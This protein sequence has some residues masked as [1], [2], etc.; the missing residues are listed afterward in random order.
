MKKFIYFFIICTVPFFSYGQ[1]TQNKNHVYSVSYKVAVTDGNQAAV[2]E[3]DKNQQVTYFD[4]LGRPT[5]SIIPNI[6]GNQEDVIS[7]FEYDD[8]GKQTKSYLPYT[9][10]LTNNLGFVSNPNVGLSSYYQTKYP[11]DFQNGINPYSETKLENSPAP[12]VLK[13]SAPGSDWKIQSTNDDHTVK[14]E[15]LFNGTNEIL[16]FEVEYTND[17]FM[18]PNIVFKGFYNQNELFITRVKNENWVTSD[19][20]LNTTETISDKNGRTILYRSFD[21]INNVVTSLD[22]YSTYDYFGNLIYTISPKASE[23]FVVTQIGVQ[24]NYNQTITYGEL[25]NYTPAFQLNATAASLSQQGTDILSLNISFSLTKGK[26]LKTGKIATL[27]ATYPDIILGNITN[28][29]YNFQ[30]SIFDNKLVI[31]DIAGIPLPT[32]NSYSYTFNTSIP[33]GAYMPPIGPE[34]LDE[35]CYQYKYDTKNRLI[36]KKLPGK[37]WQYIVYDKLNRPILTQDAIQRPQTLW[38]FVKYD[39]YSRVVYSGETLLSDTRASLQSQ[40][41][42]TTNPVLFESKTTTTFTNGGATIHYTKNTFPTS[43][44]N[45]HSVLYYDNYTFDTNGITVPTST[46]YTQSITTN[47]KALVTGSKVRTLGTNLWATT[48]VGY[49]EKARPIWTKAKNNYLATTDEIHTEIDFEGKPIK[50]K[51]IHS[52]T[53]VVANL[54]TDDNFYYDHASRLTKQTQKVASNPIELISYNKYDDLGQ[55][56]QQKVGGTAA[57]TYATTA[58]LQT[59]DYGFNVRGWLTNIN[60]TNAMSTDLFAF[61]IKY[62]DPLNNGVALYNGNISQTFWK[63]TTDNQ[64]RSYTYTYD[65]LDRI[66]KAEFKN[67]TNSAQNN[68]FNLEHV[69][70]DKNGNITFLNRAG[71]KMNQANLEWMDFLSYSYEGNKL[72]K[73]KE[74]GHGSVGFKTPIVSTNNN[75]QYFYDLNGNVKEDKNKDITSITYNYLNQPTLVV[76]TGTN[77]L[78]EYKYDASG[79]KLSKTI[80][81]GSN[82]TTTFYAGNYIYQKVNTNNPTLQFI[83]QPK[84]YI[85]VNAGTYKYVYQYKD[86]LGN[87][88]ISYTEDVTGNLKIVEENHYFPFGMKHIGYNNA[89]SSLGNSTA[90]KFKFNGQ[91]TEE[92]FDLTITEMNFRQYDQALGRFY[93]IDLLAESSV[94]ITPYHF[95]SNNPIVASDPSGLL[96]QHFNETAPTPQYFPSGGFMEMF[97]NTEHSFLWNVKNGYGLNNGFPGAGGAAGGYGPGTGFTSAMQSIGPA[98]ADLKYDYYEAITIGGKTYSK[99]SHDEFRNGAKYINSFYFNDSGNIQVEYATEPVLVGV[100]EK[101]FVPYAEDGNALLSSFSGAFSLAAL[102]LEGKSYQFFGQGTYRVGEALKNGKYYFKGDLYWKGNYP[103]VSTLMKSTMSNAKFVSNFGKGIAGVSV[104]VSLYQ[105]GSSEQTGADY[106]RLAGA[107]LITATAFIPVVGPFIS[108]GLGIADS[109]GAFD[110]LYNKFNN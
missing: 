101:V 13:Q 60:D 28:G 110:G 56:I 34:I 32:L 48:V 85:A 49:D 19:G 24:Q 6:G 54:I 79:T 27:L 2:L 17:D 35:L 91:E 55:L 38:L 75:D 18:Q 37:G 45:V 14:Y 59:V 29:T 5:Q 44:T 93:G 15:Y 52:K 97:G 40:I 103:K 73:V 25:I 109:F 106:A 33:S 31:T 30:V 63:S 96:Q 105:F 69:N 47:T 21:L 95:T 100:Y 78:I 51:S 42:N 43:I 87:I 71:D 74:E 72:L 7:Y 9:S 76:F 58:G 107:G 67:D 20:K 83:A 41:D 99:Y 104:A 68:S 92:N 84:G 16:N 66:K 36:E 82:V 61:E 10:N 64:K 22:T 46:F 4:G 50:N 26:T 1:L 11:Q 8:L 81:N 98:S 39:T 65:K 12:K 90:Q 57:S 102:V 23:T 80:T 89:V 77:K 3:S 88:R 108:V 86:H 70:Y 53:G 62:N 94:N